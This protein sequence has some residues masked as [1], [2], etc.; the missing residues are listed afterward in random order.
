MLTKENNE[1]FA[2][3]GTKTKAANFQGCQKQPAAGENHCLLGQYWHF[4]TDGVLK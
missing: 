3:Q 2:M 4:F 1:N